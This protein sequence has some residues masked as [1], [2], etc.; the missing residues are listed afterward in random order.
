MLPSYCLKEK[1][2]TQSVVVSRLGDYKE[3]ENKNGIPYRELGFSTLEE[4]MKIVPGVRTIRR[5]GQLYV[6]VIATKE[7]AHIAKLVAD[8]A[9]AKRRRGVCLQ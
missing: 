3:H 5:G 4:F 6:E 1:W 2:L 8:Q 9:N 7:S